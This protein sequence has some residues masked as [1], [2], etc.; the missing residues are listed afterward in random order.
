MAM[1][2][3]GGLVPT[4]SAVVVLLGAVALGRAWFGVI[5]VVAYGA[6]MAGALC[7]IGLLLARAGSAVGRLRILR[8]RA[9]LVAAL[10]VV[11]SLLIVGAGLVVAGRSLAQL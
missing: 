1:G 6:G 10:P 7:G 9:A 2:L 3:A 4:P 8:D 11:T 5:L